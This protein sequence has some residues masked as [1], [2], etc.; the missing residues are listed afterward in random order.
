MLK[1]TKKLLLS[2]CVLV[3]QISFG[4]ENTVVPTPESSPKAEAVKE[5]P[6]SDSPNKDSEEKFKNL[7]SSGKTSHVYAGMILTNSASVDAT[8]NSTTGF[9]TT[10]DLKTPA[11]VFGFDYL[12][13]SI[14]D[15]KIGAGFMYELQRDISTFT[16]KIG[17]ANPV[18]TTGSTQHFKVSTLSGL[19]EREVASNFSIMA[20]LNLNFVT[21]EGFSNMDYTTSGNMGFQVA[22]AYTYHNIR[23]QLMYKTVSGDITGVGKGS[24]AGLNVIGTY[25]YN[26]LVLTVGILF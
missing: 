24:S 5:Q 4:G 11:F 13:I 21:L 1:S 8:I 19:V 16:Q 17:N 23:T 18:V 3:S 14:E 20:G 26:H 9:S 15:F 6:K 10:T 7:L 22:G 25:D 12:P 2:A